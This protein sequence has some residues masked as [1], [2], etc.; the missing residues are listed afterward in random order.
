MKAKQTMSHSITKRSKLFKSEAERQKTKDII[1]RDLN[2]NVA[3]T[4][5]ER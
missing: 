3:S 4:R 5:L 1:Q 2:R